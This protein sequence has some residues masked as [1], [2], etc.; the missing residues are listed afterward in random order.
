MRKYLIISIAATLLLSYSS[1]AAEFEK[2][3]ELAAFKFKTSGWGLVE[4]ETLENFG[5][6][7]TANF[8]KDD[9][10]NSQNDTNL[11]LNLKFEASKDY[12]KLESILEVGEIYFGD[13]ATGGN[14][15]LRGK[16]VEVRYLNVEEKYGNNW[17]FKVGLFL[18]NADPRGF[19]FSDGL[20]GASLRYETESYTTQL[21]SGAGTASKPG[22]P[23]TPDT[24]TGLT[25]NQRFN[26]DTQLT[27]FG[28][29]RSTRES[30]TDKDLVTTQSGVSRYYWLGLNYD[31]QKIAGNGHVEANVILNQSQFKAENG[32]PTDSNNAWLGHVRLDYQV[33]EAWKVG[34]DTLATSGSDV[35][36]AGGTQV[37]GERKNF[38]SPAP[39]S[40]YLLTIATNDSADDMAGSTR[41]VSANHIGRLDLDQGLRMAV[42]SVEGDLN[43]NWSVL[44]RY[45]QIKSAYKNV[46]TDS[47][48]YGREADLKVKFKA[49]K[50]TSWTFEGGVFDPGSYFANQ[51]NAKLVSLAYKLEF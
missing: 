41:A 3:E 2:E 45:G 51:D 19:V 46:T 15:G 14:Q 20:T 21:W 36:R 35:A 39:S 10:N 25:H 49:S 48:D 7:V 28:A 27:V 34:L 5:D 37:L 13:S 16:N 17:Y 9:A 33:Y 23:V 50:N 11:L 43:E 31:S 26:E 30:F 40:A 29:Y 24:Y 12:L 32:G 47:T 44:I 6:G 4:N 42:F 18:V 38:A 22:N 1:F 8:N